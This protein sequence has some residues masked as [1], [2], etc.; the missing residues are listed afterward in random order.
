M[1]DD[2]VTIVMLK[3]N[4]ADLEAF[5]RAKKEEEEVNNELQRKRK[6]VFDDKFPLSRKL[7]KTAIMYCL[8][9]HLNYMI[10]VF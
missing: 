4:C 7:D 5:D 9:K 8:T 2:M 6:P 10:F 1:T 3:S